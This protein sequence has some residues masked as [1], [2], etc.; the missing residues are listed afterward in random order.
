[1][2]DLSTT[3]LGLNLRTPLVPSASPFTQELDGVRRLEDAG[4]SAIVF[5]SVFEEAAQKPES[6]AS[7][8]ALDHYVS[9]IYKAKSSVG[10]P[11]I[12][13]LGATTANGWTEYAKQ[14]QQAGADAIEVN[15][16]Q[17]PSQADVAG[18]QLEDAYIDAVKVVK[19]A[20]KIPVAAKLTAFFTSMTNMA[21][22]FDAAGADGLVLFS[23]FYQPDVNLDTMEIQPTV[24]LSTSEAL[25][26]P[27]TW[28]GM[29]YGRIKANLAG[30][31]GVH[32][33][34]DVAKLLLVGADVTMVCSALLR[35]GISHLHELETGLYRWMERHEYKS[36]TQIKGTLSQLRSA[37]PAAFE[38]SQYINAVKGIKNVVLTG[39]EA[40]RILAGE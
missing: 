8:P 27:L 9:Q 31:S 16:Y 24:L 38:R 18:A 17:V 1:M 33:A 14:I 36:V 13:S 20:V 39:R 19:A 6:V 22:R 37:D 35:N 26:L 4:A 15:L 25:R 10:M 32:T 7:R 12:A 34:E 5:H 2:L 23:R 40:W 11:V 21:K 3:Y 28:I 29:L 30:S